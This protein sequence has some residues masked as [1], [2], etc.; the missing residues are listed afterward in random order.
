M[1]YSINN[2]DR[3]DFEI[4]Y[5]G[6]A[7]YSEPIDKTFIY[8]SMESHIYVIHPEKHHVIGD[9]PLPY[10]GSFNGDMA[11]DFT[12]SV[13]SGEGAGGFFTIVYN[14]VDEFAACVKIGTGAASTYTAVN[15]L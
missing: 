13:A 12:G 8:D 5:L 2:R 9:Y 1:D 14:T 3:F 6:G 15:K 4:G 10:R 7:A 11:Y